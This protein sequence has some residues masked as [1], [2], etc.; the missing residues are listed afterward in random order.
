MLIGNRLER[1]KVEL[2]ISPLS[3]QKKCQVLPKS[4]RTVI[5]GYSDCLLELVLKQRT[6]DGYWWCS[7]FLSVD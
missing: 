3:S 1:L 5:T 2:I 6:L 4:V 7:L